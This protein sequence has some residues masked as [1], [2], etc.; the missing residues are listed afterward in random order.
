MFEV[1]ALSSMRANFRDHKEGHPNVVFI[2]IKQI[3]C[4]FGLEMIVGNRPLKLVKLHA[5]RVVHAI[6][7]KHSVCDGEFGIFRSHCIDDFVAGF[8]RN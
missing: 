6:I 4:I 5:S 7:N 2:P 1:L 3:L 8:V